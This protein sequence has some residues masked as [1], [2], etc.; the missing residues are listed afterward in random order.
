M[1]ELP[2][3]ESVRRGLE[4][5]VL[6][7]RI[8]SAKL[9]RDDILSAPGRPRSV[10]SCLLGG[11]VVE[12]IERHGKQMALVT[13]AQR[14]LIIQLGMSGRVGVGAPARNARHV[15]AIWKTDGGTVFWFQDP[16]RFGGLTALNS[17]NALRE[18]WSTLGPDMMHATPQVLKSRL[19]SGRT[20][21]KSALLDQA[22]IAGIGNIYA[23][24]ALFAAG[25]SPLRTVT[26]LSDAQR[27]KV[28]TCCRRIMRS[29][30]RMGGTT[31]SDHFSLDGTPGD[32][33]ARRVVH[34][35][36][37][38]PCVRCDRP[39]TG[40]VVGGRTTVYCTSCQD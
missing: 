1:P 27:S 12:S 40:T 4:A 21:I 6:G 29:S 11:G 36:S 28:I 35:R 31:F 18:R 39:L 9:T 25:V 38:E 34:G 22:R 23:D 17:T 37:D 7:D 16:R 15:H 8:Q 5:C 26:D 13:T 3:V 32:W 14:V 2:E 10:R 33:G 24:E 30:I 20:P 19:S